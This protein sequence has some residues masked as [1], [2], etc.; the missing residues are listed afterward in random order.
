[1]MKSVLRKDQ[2]LNHSYDL[3]QITV[4]FLIGLFSCWPCS[5]APSNQKSLPQ[6]DFP[7]K[8]LDPFCHIIGAP[9]LP[10]DSSKEALKYDRKWAE[11]PLKYLNHTPYYLPD[12][13]EH[14]HVLAPPSNTSRRTQAEL[15]YLF[16][17][18]SRRTEKQLNDIKN[19]MNLGVFDVASSLRNIFSSKNTPKTDL[20]LKKAFWDAGTIVC[21]LKK[22][23]NRPRP[24]T[25]EPKIKSCVEIPGHPAYP[26]GHSTQAHAM[27]YI[28]QELEPSATPILQL[29]ALRIACDREVAGIHYPSDTGAG[30]LLA[31]QIVDL[32]MTKKDFLEDLESAKK[33]LLHFKAQR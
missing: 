19:E 28:L 6:E 18:Q 9:C 22:K 30:Q 5:G 29:E 4:I 7:R 10:L 31:R 1:M 16:L 2:F 27:A 8:E 21:C 3:K 15:E 17:L 23:F 12:W 20:M 11:D 13:Q 32:L 24:S 14:I 33:E 26:S 25:L